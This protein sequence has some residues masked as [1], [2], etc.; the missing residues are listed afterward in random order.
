MISKNNIIFSNLHRKFSPD[1][2]SS[3]KRGDWSKNKENH[4]KW[5]R[6]YN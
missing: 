3:Q 1:L 5:K 2:K 6:N 4:F